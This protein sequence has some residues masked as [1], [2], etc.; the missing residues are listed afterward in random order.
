MLSYNDLKKGIRI[1]LDNQPY[2]IIE[3]DFMFKARGHSVLRTK[4]KNLITGNLLPK[5][6]HPSDSFEE[7]EISKIKAKYL[8]TH[9]DKFFFCKKEDHSQR[10]DLDK[11][12]IGSSAKFLKPNQIVEAVE[13]QSKIINIFLPIKIQLK[14]TEAP[15]GIKG[16]R[17]QSGTKTVTLETGVIIN[18]PLFI[19]QEDIIE[20]N[21]ETGEYTRRIE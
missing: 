3:A 20:I 18:A 10:F 17:S 4:I 9:R 6:F 15:P 13:F 21:T 2:E 19:K 5:T 14:V 11:E 7:A 1:I 16:D 12:Q 8:Y